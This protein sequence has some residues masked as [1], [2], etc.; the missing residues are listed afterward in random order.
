MGGVKLETTIVENRQ[1]L[2]LC[3]LPMDTYLQG[4]ASISQ[5]RAKKDEFEPEKFEPKRQY[6]GNWHPPL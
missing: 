3:Q 4:S 5:S 6:I 2:K 1:S